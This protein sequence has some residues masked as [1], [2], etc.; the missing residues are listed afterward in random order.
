MRPPGLA[1]ST[2]SSPPSRTAWAW[3]SLSC[4][5]WSTPTGDGFRCPASK[6]AA[7]RFGCNC[8]QCRRQ[9][10]YAG[11]FR[12]VNMG[13]SSGPVLV[14]DDDPAVGKVL[15]ALLTQA[16]I[17]NRFVSSAAQA[18]QA[19]QERPFDVLVTDLRMPGMDG[20]ELLR[21]VNAAWPETAVVM[22]TA[23]GTVPMA[24]E[25]MKAGAADFVLKPFDRE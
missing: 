15:G 23:H 20:L 7:P 5:G 25:A 1:P 10:E 2:T 19:L 14:V 3:D 18:L 12:G 8:L 24:V 21:R 13:Q 16:E 11:S 4:A 22:L 6:G 9:G 17:E